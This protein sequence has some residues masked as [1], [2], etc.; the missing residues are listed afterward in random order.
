MIVL[1]QHC[2]IISS[3]GR[4]AEVNALSREAGRMKSVTI[5]D[6]SIVYDCP[7]SMK[8]YLLIVRNALY[9]QSVTN[10]LIPP[11]IMREAGLEV[12]EIP[13]I[14]V[15]EPTMEDHLIYFSDESFRIPLSLNGIFSCF[16]T[17]RPTTQDLID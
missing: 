14:Y 2:Y 10:N 15:K 11:F 5:V 13:N 6:A 9:V 1:G 4:H 7:Y 3:S 17:R 16:Q 8:M 12:R